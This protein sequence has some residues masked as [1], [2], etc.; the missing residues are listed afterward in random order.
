MIIQEKG[1]AHFLEKKAAKF[2]KYGDIV[3]ETKRR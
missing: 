3:E 2:K 1:E